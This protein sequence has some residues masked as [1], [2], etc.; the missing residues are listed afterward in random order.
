M[1]DQGLPSRPHFYRHDIKIG[2]E[3]VVMYSRNLMQCI[4]T[5]YGNPEFAA[6]LI[7]KPERHYCRFGNEHRRIFHD[8]HTGLWWWEMQVFINFFV[9]AFVIHSFQTVLEARK[10]GTS[11]I[12]LIISSD[13]TQVTL[14]GN[15]SA[16]PVYLTIGNLPKDIRR[17]PSQHGQI[18]VAYLPTTKLKLVTNDAAR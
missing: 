4:K 10:P 8:M 16:Y 11:I 3:T 14:F 17:K 12:P 7:H 5:L 15:K 9:P 1:I 2:N 6:H 18:L 13:R